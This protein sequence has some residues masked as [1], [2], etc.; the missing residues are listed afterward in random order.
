MLNYKFPRKVYCCTCNRQF[1]QKDCAIEHRHIFFC[2]QTCLIDHV[3]K[4]DVQEW[5]IN[6]EEDEN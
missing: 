2:S 4:Y 1:K 5:E 3:L 6:Y